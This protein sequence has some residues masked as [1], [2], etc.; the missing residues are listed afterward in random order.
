MAKAVSSERLRQ[1]K[2]AYTTRRVKQEQDFTLVNGDLTPNPG[3]LLLAQ[4][5][6]LGQHKRLEL[7]TSRRATLF[8]GDEIVVAYGNRYAPDQFEGVLPAKLGRC[9][10]VAAGGVAARLLNR[11]DKMRSATRIKPL[12]LLADSD[13]RRINL[14]EYRLPRCEKL[15]KNLNHLNLSVVQPE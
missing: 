9:R 5:V 6:E 14:I 3:D 10:L 1:A 12:G 4:V 15:E 2:W 7:V 13:G 11:H 8:E